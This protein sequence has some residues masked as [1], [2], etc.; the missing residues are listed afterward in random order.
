MGPASWI[1][2]RR[3]GHPEDVCIVPAAPV[4][5]HPCRCH[6]GGGGVVVRQK[7]STAVC[8]LRHPGTRERCGSFTLGP[9]G[10]PPNTWKTSRRRAFSPV[11]CMRYKGG[12]LR[13][14]AHLGTNL[15]SPFQWS[16]RWGGEGG[17]GAKYGSGGKPASRIRRRGFF[18]IFF[19]IL[20]KATGA[21]G[22]SCIGYL[23]H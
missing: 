5:S 18:V 12:K 9:A 2:V 17:K 20:E 21:R 8:P 15:V 16:L 11:F 10:R 1:L 3:A 13:R 6:A 23:A 19:V 14:F 7:S 22:G 4:P